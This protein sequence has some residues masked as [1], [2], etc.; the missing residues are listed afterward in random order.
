MQCKCDGKISKQ[1]LANNYECFI[2]EAQLADTIKYQIEWARYQTPEEFTYDKDILINLLT[3]M[4][5]EDFKNIKCIKKMDDFKT[6]TEVTFSGIFDRVYAY[7]RFWY[8]DMITHENKYC[9]SKSNMAEFLVNRG[10]YI[11]GTVHDVDVLYLKE[12]TRNT[13]IQHYANYCIPIKQH[14]QDVIMLNLKNKNDIIEV[15]LSGELPPEK[16]STNIGY[17]ILK[18]KA[19]N[20]RDIMNSIKKVSNNLQNKKHTYWSAITN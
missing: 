15:L 8:N 10:Y 16:L 11:F 19:S 17:T 1:Y 7:E 14:L 18:G 6:Y 4:L 13:I 20:Q 3:T 2:A 5:N 9:F 12:L